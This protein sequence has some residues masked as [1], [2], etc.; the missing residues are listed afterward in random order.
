MRK[1]EE[2]SMDIIY[3]EKEDVITTSG[4]LNNGGTGSG[5]GEDCL[6]GASF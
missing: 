1:Y 3:F 2:A 4:K 5:T 6:N